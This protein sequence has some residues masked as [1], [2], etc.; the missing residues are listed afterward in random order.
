MS[1]LVRT[2]QSSISRPSSWSSTQEA[3]FRDHK[4]KGSL[5]PQKFI[6]SR[7]R[8]ILR[9]NNLKSSQALH[10]KWIKSTIVKQKTRSKHSKRVNYHPWSRRARSNTYILKTKTRITAISTRNNLQKRPKPQRQETKMDL[11]TKRLWSSTAIILTVSLLIGLKQTKVLCLW[12][13]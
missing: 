4:L 7:K 10:V 8:L 2:R 6:L 13:R 12:R 11:Y 3:K 5:R 1:Q 9:E